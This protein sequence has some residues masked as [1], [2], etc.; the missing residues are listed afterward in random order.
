[1]SEHDSTIEATSAAD[2]SSV[3]VGLI[4]TPSNA[5]RIAG[6]V[7]RASNR[8]Y[9]VFVAH[10]G[11]RSL[12]AVTFAEQLGATIVDPPE[13]GS[14]EQQLRQE[15][16]ATARSHSHSGIIFQPTPG[17]RIDYERS[18]A[19]LEDGSGSVD[20]VPESPD[21]YD[22]DTY[23]LIGIPA[24]NEGGSIGDVVQTARTYASEVL[25]VDDGSD[26]GTADAAERAG[27]TVVCHERNRGYGATLKTIFEEAHRRRTD[28]L[29]VLD[30]DG[31]HE[32]SDIPHLLDRQ[33]ETGDQIVIGSRFVDDT[34]GE[35]PFVRRIGLSVVNTLTNLSLGILH[36]RSR[37]RDTQ[38]GFRAYDR[39]AIESLATEAPLSDRMGASTD[40]L[41]H[42]HAKGYDITEVSTT[43][44]YDVEDGSTHD[45][46][47]HGIVLLHNIV[48]TVESRRPM[49][50]L[51]IPG[52]LI[53]LLG[54]GFAYWT[55]TNYLNTEIFPYGLAITSTFFVLAGIFSTFTAIILHSLNRR[56]NMG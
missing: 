36:P 19:L 5:D 38:S 9:D 46:L 39:A 11:D 50:V 10:H 17:K 55:I 47:S 31:Q 41:Y 49:T 2:N 3:A 28:H 27:A 52:V 6:S 32:P 22:G 40:I 56:L 48:R 54:A 45:P 53:T 4:A 35:V 42:A 43:V 20:A 8:G 34:D 14:D 16:R 12:E 29:V 30:G 25:V 37:I 33:R 18:K 24:Y 21:D 1:M 51:G 23:V 15:L 13:I 26:D 7:L 44:Y